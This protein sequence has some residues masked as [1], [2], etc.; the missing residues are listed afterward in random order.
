MLDRGAGVASQGFLSCSAGMRVYPGGDTS[1]GWRL[2]LSWEWW[3]EWGFPVSRD[4]AWGGW[5]GDAGL[6]VVTDS[7]LSL[8]GP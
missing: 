1:Q 6:P 5:G 8:R 4:R 2:G 7:G 3:P